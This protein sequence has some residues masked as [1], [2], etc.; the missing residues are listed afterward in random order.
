MGTAGGAVV[1]IVVLAAA[2]ALPTATL[3]GVG[4]LT[5]PAAP[6]AGAVL[7]AASA[8]GCL[9]LG[10]PLLGWFVGLAVVAAVGTVAVWRRWPAVIPFRR[11]RGAGDGRAGG[12]P[13]GHRAAGT[14][15][16]VVVLVAT[17]WSLLAL[18][19]PT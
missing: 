6:L 17:A 7:A 9:A 5:V 3:V 2:G 10:G 12:R 4:W 15:G 11:R 16:A 18:R 13:A 1:A 14:A 19:A 8:A